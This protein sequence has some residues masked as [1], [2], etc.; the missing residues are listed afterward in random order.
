MYITVSAGCVPLFRVTAIT[1]SVETQ[2][3]QHSVYPQGKVC[4]L[5]ETIEI[6]DTGCKPVSLEGAVGRECKVLPA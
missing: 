5:Q 1:V 4:L 6:I 2:K 3:G